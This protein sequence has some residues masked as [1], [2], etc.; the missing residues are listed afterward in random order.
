MNSLRLLDS[1]KSVYLDMRQPPFPY[2]VS[3]YSKHGIVLS[4]SVSSVTVLLRRRNR[5]YSVAASQT[6]RG[7]SGRWH[8]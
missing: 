4:T 5:Q 7:L 8:K 6:D 1:V 2:S 3:Y